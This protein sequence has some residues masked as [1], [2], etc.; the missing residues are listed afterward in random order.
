MDGLLLAEKNISVSHIVNGCSRLQPVVML[1]GQAIG[2][3]AALAAQKK[4]QPREVSVAKVQKHLIREERV[5]LYPF[6][7]LQHT[8]AH[9]VGIQTVAMKHLLPEDQPMVFGADETIPASEVDELA[10]RAHDLLA[11]PAKD[12]LAHH[13]PGQTRGEFMSA[14]EPLV[15]DRTVSS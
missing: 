9:F 14:I 12:V 1:T 8:H 2:V 7:D 5:L 11:V 15:S 4:I 6:N 13:R 3:I 10:K